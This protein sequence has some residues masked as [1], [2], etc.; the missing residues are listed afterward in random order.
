MRK[1]LIAE[2]PFKELAEEIKTKKKGG[3]SERILASI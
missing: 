1:R 3:Q 2:N